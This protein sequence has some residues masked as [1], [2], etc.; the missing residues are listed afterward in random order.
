M[1][2]IFLIIQASFKKSTENLVRWFKSVTKFV[3]HPVQSFLQLLLLHLLFFCTVLS[4]PL[5]F[6]TFL[7]IGTELKVLGICVKQAKNAQLLPNTL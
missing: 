5:S 3:G 7:S 1:H 4:G 2:M 6:F